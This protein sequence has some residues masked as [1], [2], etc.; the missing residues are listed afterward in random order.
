MRGMIDPDMT[1]TMMVVVPPQ[2]GAD[3]EE[4]DDADEGEADSFDGDGD[5]GHSWRRQRT[6][7]SLS[8][9]TKC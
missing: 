7:G 4:D 3:D 9:K 2:T 1:T 8:M 6:P 5:N